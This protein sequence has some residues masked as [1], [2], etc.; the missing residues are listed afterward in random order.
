MDITGKNGNNIT[1]LD[2]TYLTVG[3]N[4]I[5]ENCN[6]LE[7][8]LETTTSSKETFQRLII[9]H[10]GGINGFIKG[11]SAGFPIGYKW[12]EFITEE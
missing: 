12:L 3:K 9:V 8:N 11:C 2:E 7:R 4:T 10:G 1:Y 5:G 6:R